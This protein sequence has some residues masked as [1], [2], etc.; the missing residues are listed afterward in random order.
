L[1]DGSRI[2]IT[3]IKECYGFIVMTLGQISRKLL[4]GD[5]GGGIANAG[6]TL[7]WFLE[8]RPGVASSA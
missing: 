4:S 2:A 8:G 6:E 3:I 5:L 1:T 7:L